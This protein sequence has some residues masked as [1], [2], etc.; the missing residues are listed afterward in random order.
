MRDLWVKFNTKWDRTSITI[1]HFAVPY[2]HTP[3]IDPDNAFVSSLAS[4]DL[5]FSRDLG[6]MV[7]T[8]LSEKWDLEASLTTGGLLAQPLVS[9]HLATPDNELTQTTFTTP[10]Y[11]YNNNWLASVRVGTPTYKKNEFGVFVLAGNVLD[12]ATTGASNRIVRVGGDWTYKFKEKL[13]VMNQLV[14]GYTVTDENTR[15]YTA[16]QQTE[17]EYFVAKQLI[18]SAANNFQYNT[19][20]GQREF[21][22]QTSVGVSYAINPHTRLKLNAYLDHDYTNNARQPGVYLQFTTGLG[23]R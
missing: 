14:T 20:T 4:K 23:T 5:G 22:G 11:T 10:T 21:K 15:G 19:Y 3:R 2:G 8:P 13:K 17:V 9:I 12:D 6:I 16:I 18:L 7:K 1:G